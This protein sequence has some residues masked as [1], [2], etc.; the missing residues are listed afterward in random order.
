VLIKK[1]I[2]YLSIFV[3]LAALLFFAARGPYISNSLKKLILPELELMTGRKVIA[4]KIYINI[5]PLFVEMKDLTVFDEAGTRLLAAERLKGYVSLTG[6]FTKEMVIKRLVIRNVDTQ[7]NKAEIDEI[8]ENI[9]KYLAIERKDA[10]KVAVHT[11]I[12]DNAHLDLHDGE[13]SISTKGTEAFSQSLLAG[14]QSDHSRHA[15]VFRLCGN[16]LYNA[17]G[18]NRYKKPENRCLRFKDHKL[19]RHWN[20]PVFW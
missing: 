3:F 8:I 9:K 5:F 18:Y 10:L 7:L 15:G 14:N 16:V 17:Q 20:T 4:G 11:V 1:K 19:G 6:L 12:L 13:K 2:A